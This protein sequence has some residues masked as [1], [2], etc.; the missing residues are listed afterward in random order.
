MGFNIL[1]YKDALSD[2]EKVKSKVFSDT[3]LI[4]NKIEH[5]L[6][7]NP[8]PQGST[9]KKIKNVQPPLYR[10]RVNGIVSYRVFYRIIGNEIYI[11]RVIPKKDADKVLKKY[12]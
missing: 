12:L 1:Y 8:F 6:V 2:L 3:E 5:I 10:L 11:L 7:Q 4:L 9:I